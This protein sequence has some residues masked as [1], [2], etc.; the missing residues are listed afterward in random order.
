MFLQGW[1][2]AFG[3]GQD[4]GDSSLSVATCF[5]DSKV[6]EVYGKNGSSKRAMAKEIGRTHLL[7]GDS[8]Q[9]V[10]DIVARAFV[11]CNIWGPTLSLTL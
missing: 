9:Y 5:V 4:K 10:K 1:W 6:P 3:L 8:I 11:C 7:N 2:K